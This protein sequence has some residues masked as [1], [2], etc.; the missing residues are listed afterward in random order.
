MLESVYGCI[1]HHANGGGIGYDM[2]TDYENPY[3]FLD[4]NIDSVT[5][6]VLDKDD[7]EDFN[8]KKKPKINW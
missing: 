4:I 2:I 8:N 7:Q 1:Q 6:K 5:Y 3:G